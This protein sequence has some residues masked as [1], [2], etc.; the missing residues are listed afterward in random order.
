MSNSK[1]ERCLSK[2]EFCSLTEYEAAEVLRAYLHSNTGKVLLYPGDMR[3]PLIGLGRWGCSLMQGRGGEV[4][5]VYLKNTTPHGFTSSS[6]CV[7]QCNSFSHTHMRDDTH[8]HTQSEVVLV[9]TPVTGNLSFLLLFTSAFL[10]AISLPHSLLQFTCAVAAGGGCV[11]QH[12][13]CSE[14]GL[15]QRHTQRTTET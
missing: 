6:L 10:V 7:C 11:S 14:K 1:L 4:T 8:T 9:A 13:C 2:A 15:A 12:T 5:A 3:V